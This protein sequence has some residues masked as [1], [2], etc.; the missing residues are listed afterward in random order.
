MAHTFNNLVEAQA[1]ARANNVVKYWRIVFADNKA[2]AGGWLSINYPRE[3]FYSDYDQMERDAVTQ[4]R[5]GKRIDVST[6]WADE[7]SDSPQAR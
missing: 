2:Y 7:T 4:M 3:R 1:F 5:A 6:I